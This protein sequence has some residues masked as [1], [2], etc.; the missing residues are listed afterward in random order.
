MHH[1]RM[2]RDTRHCHAL[3]RTSISRHRSRYHHY[4][5]LLILSATGHVWTSRRQHAQHHR[6]QQSGL[7]T[8]SSSLH[9]LFA[10]LQTRSPTNLRCLSIF[11]P[12]EMPE[13][14]VGYL[15]ANLFRQG[16][17]DQKTTSMCK[18]MKGRWTG[19][20]GDG[21]RERRAHQ[22]R[23]DGAP[24]SLLLRLGQAE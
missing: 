8:C 17:G 18:D 23:G 10:K 22:I 21:R 2:T 14:R 3:V 4:G 20:W 7:Y 6:L 11:A 13:C 1:A 9:A 12:S 16:R 5:V 24:G 19:S 15:I